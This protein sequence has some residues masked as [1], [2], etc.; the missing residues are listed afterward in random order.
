MWLRQ[1]HQT[2]LKTQPLVCHSVTTAICFEIKSTSQ[3]WHHACLDLQLY[4]NL[5]CPSDTFRQPQRHQHLNV[6]LRR[7]ICECQATN[8]CYNDTLTY[9]GATAPKSPQRMEGRLER[10]VQRMVLRQHLHQE[11]AMGQ[12]NRAHLPARRRRRTA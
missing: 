6:G 12:A 5:N 8:V 2:N 1:P 9:L 7:P 11:V 3:T 10:T 4:L